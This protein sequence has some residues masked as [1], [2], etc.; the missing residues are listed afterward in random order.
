MPLI[1]E[2]LADGKIYEAMDVVGSEAALLNN[3]PGPARKISSLRD[4]YGRLLEFFKNGY[5]DPGRKGMLS[6]IRRE[7]RE[8]ASGI[9]FESNVA[10]NEGVYFASVRADRLQPENFRK[11]WESYQSMEE[12]VNFSDVNSSSST[13]LLEKRDELLDRAFRK[14]MILRSTDSEDDL[15]FLRSALGGSGFSEKSQL[16]MLSAVTLGLM[17]SY[18]RG[19]LITL[20]DVFASSEAS[21]MKARAIAGVLI[22]LHLYPDE[23]ASDG[24]LML[25]LS[26]MCD[27]DNINRELRE[28]VLAMI[29]TRDTSRVTDKFKREVLD[30]FTKFA[31]K[32]KMPD[33]AMMQ[34]LAKGEEMEINPEWQKF[35]EDSGIEKKL[36]KFS[37]M[38]S[39]GA[40]LMM[41]TFAQLKNFSFFRSVSSW[42]LPFDTTHSSLL[43]FREM[44]SDSMEAFINLPGVM[45]DSDKY[46]LALSLSQM[47]AEQ[48]LMLNTQMDAQQEQMKEELTSIQLKMSDPAFSNEVLMSM[49]SLYRFIRLFNGATKCF[50]DPF[51]SPLDV[52][53][54]PGL[55]EIL[56]AEDALELVSE[57]YFKHG[58][59]EESLHLFELRER[60]TGLNPYLAEKTGYCHERLLNYPKAREYYAKAELLGA[61]GTWILRRMFN[62]LIDSE[63]H[64]ALPYIEKLYE[65]DPDSIK[66]RLDYVRTLQ[67][68]GKEDELINLLYKCY[69][70]NPELARTTLLL[71]RTELARGN[72][73][74]C[75]L[76]LASLQESSLSK[77]EQ[78][79]FNALTGV[80]SILN[81]DNSKGI[82]YLRKLGASSA[83]EELE[84]LGEDKLDP[85][86]RNLIMELIRAK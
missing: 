15:L 53:R 50:S 68:V 41:I 62:V 33:S 22:A 56:C 42:F 67:M 70:E 3:N 26:G 12:M 58:Y 44:L 38:Q 28:V 30:N 52:T 82:D 51:L 79:E 84:Q 60:K 64:N 83:E 76:T 54:I 10:N 75:L 74:K 72:A 25:R 8:L 80:A 81:G 37:E 85:D 4:T 36:M 7:L 69:F 11:L 14:C 1:G 65:L 23:I 86:S 43:H 34:A 40:D 31:S 20:L 5:P 57:F 32:T 78:K 6:S 48:R 17:A 35:L 46:S 19:L 71:A 2:L 21:K 55:E 47:P 63:P 66:V 13:R 9:E 16:V 39:E 27:S 73:D 45:C 61:S 24:E 59:Y 77:E 49:R 18:D 29:R